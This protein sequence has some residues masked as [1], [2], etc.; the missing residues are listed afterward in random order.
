MSVSS[1]AAIA[2]NLG[3]LQ[4]NVRNLKTLPVSNATIVVNVRLPRSW[5]SGT[6]D[7]Y[8]L[9]GHYSRGCTN[10]KPVEEEESY[11]A[12][13]TAQSTPAV[14]APVFGVPAFEA[15]AWGASAAVVVDDG[16]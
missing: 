1:N 5:F 2:M 6:T 3:I 7:N 9:V 15:P 14:N 12:Y 8:F 4:R 10:E 16:W 11:D 13:P